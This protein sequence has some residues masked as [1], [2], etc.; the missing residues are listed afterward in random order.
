[1]ANSE[2][3]N[4]AELDTTVILCTYNRADSLPAILESLAA[5]QLPDSITWE[6]LVT[7]N[8]ST[9][10]TREVVD[11]FSHRYPD[12]FR[13]L[14]EPRPGKC[15][16]LNTAVQNARGEILAFLDD[17]VKIEPKW[18][19]NLTA[20]LRTGEWVG[21]G[22]RILPAQAFTLPRWLPSSGSAAFRRARGFR[23]DPRGILYGHFDLGSGASELDSYH[24]PYGANMAFRKS[25]FEKYGGFQELGVSNGSRPRTWEDTEF[26]RRL[27]DAGERLRYEPLA[28]VYHP[29]A[30]ERIKKEY[31]LSWWFDFGRTNIRERG[32]RPDLYG[33]PWDY[34]SLLRR[35]ID[36]SIMSLRAVFAI[37]PDSRFS[38]RCMVWWQAGM[39]VELHHRLTDRVASKAAAL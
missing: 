8:N 15:H 21:A 11:D 22:G 29:V 38:S 6:I 28:I 25:M 35:A 13:Y 16:A 4:C 18:L 14:F 9:D 23:W 33:I 7:D 10:R 32:D 5:S 20:G 36:I 31:F 17:D 30:Q 19:Q 3:C 37:H 2:K 24:A 34:W 12:R 39:I 27:I 26:G 1:M